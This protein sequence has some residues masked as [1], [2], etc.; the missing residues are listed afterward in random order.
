MEAA[1]SG[2]AG[3]RGSSDATFMARQPMCQK[4]SL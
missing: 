1:L 4:M 2:G 3:P